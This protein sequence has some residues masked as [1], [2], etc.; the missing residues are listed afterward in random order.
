VSDRSSSTAVDG[1]LSRIALITGGSKRLGRHL[2]LSLSRLGYGVVINYRNSQKEAEQLATKIASRGRYARAVR[3]DVG[4][5]V[6]V[7]TMFASIEQHEARLDLLINNVGIYEPERLRDVTPEDWDECIQSNLNGA[8]YCCYHARPLL[9]QTRGQI[10]NIGYA[11]VD[12]LVANPW[13]TAY[14]VSKTGLL[15]LTKS[16]GEALAPEV[17]VNMVSPGQLENSVD[18]P[19]D[20]PGTIP[21]A[22]AGTLND[23]AKAVEYLLDAD[24]VTGVNLD[25][26]GGYRLGGN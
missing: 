26:A 3:A 2:A 10:I 13:A 1:T 14:Q 12:A 22:R 7:A 24:Y 6:D 15:V 17:R 19:Q 9:E 16:L 5:K 25:V 23:I 20:L 18:L 8:F 4:D 21:M 11:G